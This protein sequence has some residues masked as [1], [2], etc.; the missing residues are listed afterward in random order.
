MTHKG[1]L[2]R[3]KILAAIDAYRNAH[4]YGPTYAEIAHAVDLHPATVGRHVRLM[5]RWGTV[6]GNG[7]RTRSVEVVQ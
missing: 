5:R 2:N 3:A 7:R 4:G 1:D 6:R